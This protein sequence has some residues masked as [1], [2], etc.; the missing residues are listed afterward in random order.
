MTV[1]EGTQLAGPRSVPVSDR[2]TAQ[3]LD[4]PDDAGIAAIGESPK[5]CLGPHREGDLD[6][7]VARNAPGPLGGHESLSVSTL[8]RT[9]RALATLELTVASVELPL[10]AANAPLLDR[11]LDGQLR[12]ARQLHLGHHPGARSIVAGASD[13]DAHPVDMPHSR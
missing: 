2:P 7:P 13:P 9:V 4:R 6:P 3:V 12:L 11:V 10:V 8:D 5:P 1:V